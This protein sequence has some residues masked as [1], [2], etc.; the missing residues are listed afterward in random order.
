MIS[1]GHEGGSVYRFVSFIGDG[2]HNN[3]E[4]HFPS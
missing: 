2:K 3:T 4:L 1:L